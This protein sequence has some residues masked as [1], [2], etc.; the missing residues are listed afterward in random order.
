[1]PG[2]SNRTA[3][4]TMLTPSRT[5]TRVLAPECREF[6]VIPS[7]SAA[8]G[9]SDC[10]ERGNAAMK[11]FFRRLLKAV[12]EWGWGLRDGAYRAWKF[13]RVILPVSFAAC[14]Y[15]P[16]WPASQ[17]FVASFTCDTADVTTVNHATHLTDTC[18]ATVRS[19]FLTPFFVICGITFLIEILMYFVDKARESGRSD[20]L[21][22]LKR[23]QRCAIASEDLA[24]GQLR[25]ILIALSGRHEDRVTLYWFQADTE[26]F[27]HFARY[28]TH[29]IYNKKGRDSLRGGCIEAAWQSGHTVA[30]LP[31]RKADLAEYTKAQEALGLL[32][33]TMAALHMPTRTYVGVRLDGL[34]QSRLAA[35]LM[36]E[37]TTEMTV[38]QCEEVRV[39]IAGDASA[40]LRMLLDFMSPTRAHNYAIDL[41]AFD[42]GVASARPTT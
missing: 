10:D 37:S 5:W 25:E 24:I 21:R 20:E 26:V 41:Q 9:C 2:A 23:V 11:D 39:V 16:S 35:V 3:F 8:V 42:T 36:F 12:L 18:D 27:E 40:N 13:L 33:A 28:S 19:W 34:K 38:E 6:A 29:P 15:G 32:P 4:A 17:R 22:N 30:R 7:S 1:M 31:D 14:P